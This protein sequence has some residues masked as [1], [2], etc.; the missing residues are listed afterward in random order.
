MFNP[1]KHM[2]IVAVAVSLLMTPLSAMAKD[3]Y[4]DTASATTDATMAADA[5]VVRPLGIVSLVA[6]FGLFIVSSPFSALGGNIGE[7]W[8]T[9]V[10]APATFTF[11]RPLG[12]F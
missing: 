4:G 9:F 8:E 6:G 2:M 7:A 12:D 11:A 1:L 10:T 5:I 3:V